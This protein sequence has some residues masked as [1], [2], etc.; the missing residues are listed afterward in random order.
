MWFAIISLSMPLSIGVQLPFKM[1]D[2]FDELFVVE[3]PAQNINRYMIVVNLI[4]L[5]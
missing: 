5:V 3:Q 4:F 1:I 2:R